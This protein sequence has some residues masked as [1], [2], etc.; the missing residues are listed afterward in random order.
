VVDNSRLN[1]PESPIYHL[2]VELLQQIFLFIVHDIPN[3]PSIF[4]KRSN[5]VPYK[6]VTLANFAA[7]PLLF[8]WVC[9]LWRVVAYSTP[10]IWS[11]IYVDLPGEFEPLKPSLPSLLRFWLAQSG[12]QPLTL[13]IHLGHLYPI[14]ITHSERP[15]VSQADSQLL[16]ILLFEKGRW[17]TVN[18]C[19]P[20]TT[21][22]SSW[23]HWTHP[24]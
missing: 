14:G 2:P 11:R 23:T 3:Y 13:R 20:Y 9:H 4:S 24:S 12:D 21:G 18:L 10:G 19:H 16:D 6:Y 8:T 1:Y 7:P 5:P 15:Q 17:E 22:M